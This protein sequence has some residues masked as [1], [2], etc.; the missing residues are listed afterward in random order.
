MDFLELFEFN[1]YTPNTA[2]IATDTD[3]R[4]DD[5]FMFR[6]GKFTGSKIKELMKVERGTAQMPWGAPEKMISFGDGA[7]AYIYATA[8]GRQRDKYLERSIGKNSDYGEEA[9]AI[10]Q[11]FLE[12]KYPHAT[13]E[14]VGFTEF[15]EGVAGAS[16]DGKIAQGPKAAAVEMKLS[17][18]WET[19]MKRVEK[20][21]DA[22][23]I[24]FWQCQAEM[25][26]LETD[27][28]IYCVAEPPHSLYEMDITHVEFMPKKA[29]K[30]HQHC[31]IERC[32]IGNE[33]INKFLSGMN[34]YDAVQEVVT[35]WEVT[36]E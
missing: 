17:T 19:F 29:D 8:K 15:I 34:F 6:N 35:N 5:W 26:A 7:L 3:Q 21:F 32:K 12:R 1:E 11:Q 20:P 4:T 24:D 28:L 16:P 2:N 33:I 30:I 10:V 14:S 25:L 18:T 23:H 31:I 9:E 22:S 27:N 13:F 36:Y